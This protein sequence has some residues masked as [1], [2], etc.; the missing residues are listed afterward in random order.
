MIEVLGLKN[1]DK[2]RKAVKSLAELDQN[3]VLRDIRDDP[4]DE[5]A[6]QLL[7][8]LFSDE[9]LNTR[10]TTWRTLSPDLRSQPAL[11]LL[12]SHPVLMKRPIIRAPNKVTLGWNQNVKAQ[13]GL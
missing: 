12:Q 10:S 11:G 1:C 6:F 13:W 3:V 2:C 4:I 8:D 5:T 9:L 7:F